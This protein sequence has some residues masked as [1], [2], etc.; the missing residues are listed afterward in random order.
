MLDYNVDQLIIDLSKHV[1]EQLINATNKKME[2]LGNNPLAMEKARILS[3]F[4]KN[5]GALNL[6]VLANDAQRNTP[7]NFNAEQKKQLNELAEKFQNCLALLSNNFNAEQRKELDGLFEKFQNYSAS[8]EKMIM[9]SVSGQNKEKLALFI[10]NSINMS[11]GTIEIDKLQKFDVHFK[12]A[13]HA[14][15]NSTNRI[16]SKLDIVPQSTVQAKARI[17]EKAV[18]KKEKTEIRV[19]SREKVEENQE[20]I[21]RKFNSP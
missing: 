15:K 12:G 17:E 3:E 2:D 9:C 16:F 21:T 5:L 8:L 13:Q 18:L 7:K 1:Q 10:E 19:E 11:A 4:K 20:S 6:S 14:G